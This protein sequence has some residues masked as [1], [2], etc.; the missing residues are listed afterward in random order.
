[1]RAPGRGSKAGMETG[2]REGRQA[3]VWGARKTLR[4]G[5]STSWSQPGWQTELECLRPPAPTRASR[6]AGV[7]RADRSKSTGSRKEAEDLPVC[8]T[9]A[10]AQVL[11]PCQH[12]LIGWSERTRSWETNTQDACTRRYACKNCVFL[13][14]LKWAQWMT[15]NIWNNNPAAIKG[16]SHHIKNMALSWCNTTQNATIFNCMVYIPKHCLNQLTQCNIYLVS[17]KY[18]NYYEIPVNLF[19]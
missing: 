12:T 3:G 17:I 16:T 4:G 18:W 15:G 9:S 1:M 10:E 5:F 11:A 7:I 14:H 19:I 6:H 2:R 13:F 8:P